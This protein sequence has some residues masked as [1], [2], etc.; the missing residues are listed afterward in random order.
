MKH[1][2]I[3]LIFFQIF[4]YHLFGEDINSVIYDYYY[5]NFNNIN[6]EKGRSSA[7]QENKKQKDYY[8]LNKINDK[9]LN[10]AWVE[11]A[12]GD[13]VGEYV[14]IPIFRKETNSSFRYNKKNDIKITFS[15][16]NG[17]CKSSELFYKNNRIKTAKITIFVIPMTTAQDGYPSFPYEDEENEIL[18]TKVIELKDIIESQT[19]EEKINIYNSNYQYDTPF[20]LLKFEIIDVYKGTKYDD[21]CIS[22]MNVY[23]EYVSDSDSN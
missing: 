15:I 17:F 6:W 13:G 20:V 1:K 5:S 14:Y 3:I 4:I 21:T 12:E 23:G 11:G 16:F 10:T 18:L 7:L 19:F 2:L 22:E 8:E 9:N